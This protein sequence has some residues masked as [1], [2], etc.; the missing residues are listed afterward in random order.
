MGVLDLDSIDIN[1]F[2]ETD[3]YFL[4]QL[5]GLLNWN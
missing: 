3:Q 1:T 4:E 2:D 5:T